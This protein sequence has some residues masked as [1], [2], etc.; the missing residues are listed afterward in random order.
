MCMCEYMREQLSSDTNDYFGN[1]ILLLFLLLLVT[2]S[3]LTTY[4]LRAFIHYIF[5]YILL[6][7]FYKNK[8]I[9]NI[10]RYK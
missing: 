3:F 8:K 4:M 1:H 5:Y 6:P 7:T 9:F 2:L 10:S